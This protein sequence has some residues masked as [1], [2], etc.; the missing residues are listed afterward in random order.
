[1]VFWCNLHNR[2]IRRAKKLVAERGLETL[3]EENMKFSVNMAS[4][5]N[6]INGD[7]QGEHVDPAG[8]AC[9]FT[10]MEAKLKREKF[11]AKSNFTRAKKQGIVF[12]R[13]AG[14]ARPPRN[15]GCV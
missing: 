12:T 1:M 4:L 10:D 11:R 3:I 8:T 7:E 13:P 9:D 5:E 15:P 6:G 14:K 2:E